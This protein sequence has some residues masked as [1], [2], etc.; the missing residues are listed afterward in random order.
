MEGDHGYHL[1]ADVDESRP[2]WGGG[3]RPPRTVRW[4]RLS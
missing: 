3:G 2:T 4:R 1:A